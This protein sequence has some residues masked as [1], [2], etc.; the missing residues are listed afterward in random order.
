MGRGLSADRDHRRH[1]RLQRDRGRLRHNCQ[2]AV[3]HLPGAVSRRAGDRAVYR[4]QADFLISAKLWNLRG[5][6]GFNKMLTILTPP[7]WA[8]LARGDAA[9]NG[10]TKE[11]AS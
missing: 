2:G 9:E 4:Q 8:L 1:F 10:V 11:M 5:S 3:W 6:H 7:P